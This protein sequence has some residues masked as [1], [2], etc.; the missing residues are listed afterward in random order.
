MGQ[1]LSTSSKSA[2]RI[3]PHK[4]EG[5]ITDSASDLGPPQTALGGLPLLTKAKGHFWYPANGP[6]ILD[7]CGGAGVACLGHGRRDIIKA[8]N[9]QMNSLTYA[10]YAHFKISPVQELSDWLIKSTDNKMQKVYIMSSGKPISPPFPFLFFL[11]YH[12][13]LSHPKA[14]KR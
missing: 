7:A 8:V 12:P 10:S 14:R 2:R 13:N 5:D 1:F 9:A 11:S 4:A 3:L 6:K